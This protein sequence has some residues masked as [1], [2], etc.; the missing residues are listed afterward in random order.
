M[1]ERTEFK[2]YY[3]ELVKDWE[4]PGQLLARYRILKC[5]RQGEGKELYLVE[6]KEDFRRCVIKLAYGRQR[7][8]LR[9]EAESLTELEKTLIGPDA[10]ER[11]ARS[12]GIVRIYGVLEGDGYTALV[13][14]YCE[15]TTL[16]RITDSRGG[17]TGPEIAGYGIL[18]CEILQ[19]LH[20]MD[21]PMIHRDVKPEN[22]LV[23]EEN[24]LVLLDFDT[25]RRY[26]PEKERDTVFL[27]SKDTAAPEQFGCGQT[28][29]RSDV[30][31][32]GR[33]LLYLACGCYDKKELDG[34][35]C[36]EKL[37]KVIRRAIEFEPARR[38]QK[39]G[40]LREE[41]LRCR[42]TKEGSRIPRRELRRRLTAAGF[43]GAAAG[44]AVTAL[45]CGTVWKSIVNG[46]GERLSAEAGGI[47]PVWT[48][49]EDVFAAEGTK[50]PGTG[51]TKAGA[52]AGESETGETE[53]KD[54]TGGFSLA[55]QMGITEESLFYAGNY[56][57]LLDQIFSD[58]AAG[59]W[60]SLGEDSE[61]LVARLY[62]DPALV[63]QRE[64]DF[65]MFEKENITPKE[66]D[67]LSWPDKIQFWFWYRDGLLESS[68]ELLG[69]SGRRIAVEL[70]NALAD[71]SPSGQ[72]ALYRYI[73]SDDP[74]RT[75]DTW[76]LLREYLSTLLEV[77]KI[78]TENNYK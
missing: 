35:D 66:I 33:T 42:D 56:R 17:L 37:K 22:V 3:E 51:G 12:F 53:A 43:V 59:D 15:G 48:M 7:Q 36:S 63:L 47:G 26:E 6:D 62:A 70:D 27:G 5:I 39:I 75:V 73:F 16:L 77:A 23:T 28:D 4:L 49:G 52:E 24:R 55:A 30:Y 8:F 2:E 46:D 61:T 68:K 58:Y 78:T 32:A 50:A 1:G 67:R 9:R 54:G 25:V 64:T 10:G 74:S 34:A 13:R 71:D 20:S 21:P 19:H 41:L 65:A 45:V 72:T 40:E 18:L 11:T 29:V 76:E 60:G 14:E 69:E 38:Y 57:E 31:G 44:A